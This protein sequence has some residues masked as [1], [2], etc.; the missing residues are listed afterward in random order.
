MRKL[1]P[2]QAIERT[3]A[4][5]FPLRWLVHPPPHSTIHSHHPP[6]RWSQA[7]GS[8]DKL[9]LPITPQAVRAWKPLESI[10]SSSSY[11]QMVKTK[12]EGGREACP[13][14]HSNRARIGSDGQ[15]PTPTHSRKVLDEAEGQC[16]RCP[17]PPTLFQNT[18]LRSPRVLSGDDISS[19][20]NE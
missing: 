2:S 3:Q 17:A 15:L 4:G 9:A 11:L 16:G 7:P 5:W 13:N 18:Q 1:I 19:S 12:A 8:G 20:S 14:S 6:W 10:Q